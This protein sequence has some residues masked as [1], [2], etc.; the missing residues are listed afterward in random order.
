MGRR[1]E[2]LGMKVAFINYSFNII[3]I[4]HLKDLTYMTIRTKLKEK[5][6]SLNNYLFFFLDQRLKNNIITFFHGLER[7][8]HSVNHKTCLSE[9]VIAADCHTNN[10]KTQCLPGC[11]VP[12]HLCLLT[13]A[14]LISKTTFTRQG[15]QHLLSN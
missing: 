8:V 4:Q 1:R 11:E 7:K 15:T 10:Y 13:D 2:G 12:E 14:T 6:T 3:T 5:N 9:K